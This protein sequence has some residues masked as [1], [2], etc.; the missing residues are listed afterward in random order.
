MISYILG[1]TH[2]DGLVDNYYILKADSN[3]NQVWYYNYNNLNA[4]SFRD[5]I[6]TINT[7]YLLVGDT[8]TTYDSDH[9]L[10]FVKTE[11]KIFRILSE[12]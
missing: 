11:R 7:G 12:Y 2:W 5:V 4:V 3:G 1:G 10:L 6:Q 8:G 9:D